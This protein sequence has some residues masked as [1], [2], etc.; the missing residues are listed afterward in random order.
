[1]SQKTAERLLEQYQKYNDERISDLKTEMRTGFELL[2]REI[3]GLNAY[4]M[5]VAGV[6]IGAGAVLQVLFII[7]LKAVFGD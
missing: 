6:V 3:R 7:I 5:K 1:M 2:H 4:K